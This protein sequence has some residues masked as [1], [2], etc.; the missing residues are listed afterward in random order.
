MILL[1]LELS[2]TECSQEVKV[3]EKTYNICVI[4]ISVRN[5][6]VLERSSPLSK[7]YTDLTV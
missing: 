5:N 4:K 3:L 1:L 7:T 2:P 6:L